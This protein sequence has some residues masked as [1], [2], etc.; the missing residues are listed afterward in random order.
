MTDD[1]NITV[2]TPEAA[3]QLQQDF[4]ELL[5]RVNGDMMFVS[6]NPQ[7]PISVE[8]A[9]ASAE[10]SIDSHM[11]EFATNEALHSLSQDLKQRFR[12]D[13]LNQATRP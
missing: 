13:I 12:A 2:A 1:L 11:G 3:A 4:D 10:R 7:D 5:A 8:A 6:M 9:I